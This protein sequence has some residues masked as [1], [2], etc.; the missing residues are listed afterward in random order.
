MHPDK[1]K[2]R[3]N[4][5][6]KVKEKEDGI[7]SVSRFCLNM[8]AEREPRRKLQDGHGCSN[9]PGRRQLRRDIIRIEVRHLIYMIS[10]LVLVILL[11]SEMR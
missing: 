5:I 6:D 1:M 2:L 8:A 7:H 3:C 9:Q 4:V 10:S 11:N